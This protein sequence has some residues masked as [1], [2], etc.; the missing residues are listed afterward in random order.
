MRWHG[1]IAPGSTFSPIV[2]HIDLFPT[3]MALIGQTVTHTIDGVN[4]LPFILR[5]STTSQVSDDHDE[6]KKVTKR[7][8]TA[9]DVEDTADVEDLAIADDIHSYSY[10]SRSL[11]IDTI[12]KTLFWRSG[13][14]SALR[15]GYW[16]IQKSSNPDKL[17][18]FNLE[19]DSRERN[20]LAYMEEYHHRLQSML[21][22]LSEENAK[23]VPALWP[24]VSQTPFLL[25]KVWGEAYE[26]SDE[27]VY[28]PNWMNY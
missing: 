28:W 26:E 20:N 21:V 16:K 2:S 7:D 15:K 22:L 19:H 8:D 17:W 3:I 23:Q 5:K 12:H 9:T 4:I 6:K 25:D 24:S 11:P 18:L 13:H 27:Y 10:S 14:Y 1:H